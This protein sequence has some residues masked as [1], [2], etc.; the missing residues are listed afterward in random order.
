[1]NSKNAGRSIGI[2]NLTETAKLHSARIRQKA[3]RRGDLKLPK[4]YATP[5]SSTA[6]PLELPPYCVAETIRPKGYEV[7]LRQ[8]KRDL[9][10]YRETIA[11]GCRILQIC[12]AAFVCFDS[13]KRSA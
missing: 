11:D 12:G 13:T 5:K 3:Q 8:A 2:E 7:H 9:V 4:R 1:M 10:P 6:L